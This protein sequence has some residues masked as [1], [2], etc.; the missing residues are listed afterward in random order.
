M[1]L[2]F[3]IWW[4]S[5]VKGNIISLKYE[6]KFLLQWTHTVVP[7]AFSFVYAF[8]LSK[9]F[10]IYCLILSSWLDIR[11]LRKV[12]SYVLCCFSL[13]WL[14]ATPWTAACPA[15]RSIGFSRQEYWS[16]LPCP[17]PGKSF[18]NSGIETTSPGSPA[19]AGRF[20]T[21]GT[22][23]ERWPLLPKFTKGVTAQQGLTQ[24]PAQPST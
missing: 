17:P 22:T 20:F 7:Y 16:G 23:W 24:N 12:H 11:E 14:F 21:T 5:Q 2:S 13:V 19:L 4:K 8:Y 1:I 9:D 15:P 6:L 10:H 18:F 3:F